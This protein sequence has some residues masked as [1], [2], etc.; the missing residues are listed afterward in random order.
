MSVEDKYGIIQ[1]MIYLRRNANDKQAAQR[2]PDGIHCRR[3]HLERN[4]SV[5]KEIAKIK[6]YGPV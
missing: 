2:R 6:C 3:Q 1:S 5:Q 4:A